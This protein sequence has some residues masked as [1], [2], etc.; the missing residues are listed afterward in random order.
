MTKQK[1]IAQLLQQSTT[2]L[3]PQCESARLDAELLLCHCIGK[4]RTYLYTWPE[5]T[6]TDG[7]HTLFKALLERRLHGEPLAYLTGCKEFWSL[8][9]TVTPDTLIPRPETEL[10][11]ELCLSK[12]HC[13]EGPFLDLGTGTGA[14]AISVAT[15]L[16]SQEVFAIE[17]SQAALK[18]AQGNAKKLG[19]KINFLQS[20]W[21]EQLEEQAFSVIAANPPYIAADDLHLTRGG[22]PFE[23]IQALRS[24]DDGFAD[25]TAIINASPP[26]LQNQGW[27]LI[28]HGHT[29]GQRT[30]ELML[31]K[32]FK[33]VQTIKDLA[34]ND[35]VT[36]GQKA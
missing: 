2:Q 24:S 36:L 7:Q 26:Y 14:I 29:Q 16:P 12:L 17:Y 10:M 22:L 27:L 13:T 21:F 32:H 15:E 20:D 11:V 4:A 1:T 6:L 35:R 23:P 19:A 8:E 9:F 25:I 33:E 5:K 30:R 3:T 34:H 18:V 28:E 31:N